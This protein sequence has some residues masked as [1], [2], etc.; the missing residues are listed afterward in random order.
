MPTFSAGHDDGTALGTTV[1]ESGACVSISTLLISEHSA[2]K[3]SGHR[4]KSPAGSW[5][6][7]VKSYS[8]RE[9]RR[10]GS[11]ERSSPLLLHKQSCGETQKADKGRKQP[12]EQG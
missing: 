6:D 1:V 2:A 4:H 8:E 5:W 10:M 7:S 12:G 9:R 3:C 11:K